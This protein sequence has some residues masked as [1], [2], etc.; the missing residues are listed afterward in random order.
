MLIVSQVIEKP[1]KSLK[2]SDT[3]AAIRDIRHMSTIIVPDVITHI[4]G[5]DLLF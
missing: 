5:S 3:A 1:K 4:L 2:L